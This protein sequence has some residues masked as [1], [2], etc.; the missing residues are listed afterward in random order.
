[1]FTDVNL[2]NDLNVKFA[3]YVK[4]KGTVLGLTFSIMV[5]QVNVLSFPGLISWPTTMWGP[6][7]V[8]VCVVRL[9]VRL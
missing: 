3:E 8:M 1:M 2:S 9:S 4:N 5:L 7:I 6:A